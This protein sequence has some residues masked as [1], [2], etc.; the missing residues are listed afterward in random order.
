MRICTVDIGLDGII[1]FSLQLILQADNNNGG[2]WM[3]RS[4]PAPKTKEAM[5]FN[6]QLA[7]EVTDTIRFQKVMQFF[8]CLFV[9]NPP[10]SP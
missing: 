6:L 8:F 4:P 10:F 9:L 7:A 2:K 3:E 5:Q 1:A